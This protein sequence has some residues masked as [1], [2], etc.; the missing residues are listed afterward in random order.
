MARQEPEKALAFEPGSINAQE[1]CPFFRRLPGEARDLI[2]QYA[3]AQYE[4]QDP[5]KRFDMDTCYKRPNYSA[6]YICDTR[7]LRTCRRIY[8]EAWFRPWTSFQHIFYLAW[9]SRRPGDGSHVIVGITNMERI[10]KEI[11]A[12]HGDLPLDNGIRI[13]AQLCELETG[14]AFGDIMD[15]ECF[16]PRTITLTIRHTD[17]WNWESDRPLYLDSAW[18]EMARLPN[19][20]R[21]FRMEL[22]SLERR[23]GQ[24]DAIAQQMCNSWRLR[25]KDCTEMKASEADCEVERWTGSSTWEGQRWLEDETA[26]APGVLQYYVKTVIFRPLKGTTKTIAQSQASDEPKD[27]LMARDYSL[28]R[29]EAPAVGRRADGL[30]ESDE[31][32]DS[33]HTVESGTDGSEADLEPAEEGIE[34]QQ[35]SDDEDH[36]EAQM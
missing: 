25:R 30:Q 4:N 6:S 34:L 15:M 9:A 8:T 35:Y 29:L 3:L 28:P 20:V 11:H 12:R 33:E 14:S 21:E 13:F 1:D 36:D 16:F 32:S 17:W 10:L 19:G 27:F 18:A 26:Q 24:I 22:E 23:K 7:L 2:F 31:D 5:A